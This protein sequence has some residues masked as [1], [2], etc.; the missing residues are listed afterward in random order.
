MI[1]KGLFWGNLIGITVLILQ[2][3][4]GFITL[5]P[6][7]YYVSTVPID[8]N[9]FAILALNVGTLILCFVML[10]IPSYIITK[11]NPSKSIQFA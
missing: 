10:I 3:Q 2:Q 1:L 11:I 7:T 5:D 4:F 6:S 9:V 8:I